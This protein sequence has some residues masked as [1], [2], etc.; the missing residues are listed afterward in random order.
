M[1]LVDIGKYSSPLFG[2][3]DVRPLT[4]ARA[5]ALPSYLGRAKMVPPCNDHHID[6]MGSHLGQVSMAPGLSAVMAF[7]IIVGDGGAE[8]EN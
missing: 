4:L 2:S 7:V 3:N 6:V 8:S 1:P 5:L